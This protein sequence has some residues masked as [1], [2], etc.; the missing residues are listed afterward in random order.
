MKYCF[1]DKI[2]MASYSL[3]RDSNLILDSIYKKKSEQTNRNS[4]YMYCSGTSILGWWSELSRSLKD[5]YS[6]DIYFVKP[7]YYNISDKLDADHNCL[8]N[9]CW[10]EFESGLGLNDSYYIIHVPATGLRILN[11]I[12]SSSLNY[13]FCGGT[14]CY[15]IYKKSNTNMVNFNKDV[16]IKELNQFERIIYKDILLDIAFESFSN[17]ISQYHISPQTRTKAP[18]IY[19]EWIRSNLADENI[20]I[21]CAF[22]KNQPVGFSTISL[23][24]KA[25]EI[26]L[27][28]VKREFRSKGLYREIMRFTIENYLKIHTPIIISTQID[29]YS[30]QRVWSYHGFI[31][32]YTFYNFHI[33]VLES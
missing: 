16:L 8:F 24:G 28:A 20:L 27:S 29:N 30:V 15:Y 26:L 19:R 5:V 17:Y 32:Y 33:G 2:I 31:P 12:N 18:L 4:F 21:I 9:K 6:R 13:I 7:F 25:Y 10:D 1:D 23:I 3:T 22:Y 11:R 14:T